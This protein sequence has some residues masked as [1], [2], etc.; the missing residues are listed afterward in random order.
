MRLRHWRRCKTKSGQMRPAGCSR[1][2]LCQQTPCR[3]YA[4]VKPRVVSRRQMRI[5]TI[6]VPAV[7]LFRSILILVDTQTQATT[8]TATT[9][10]YNGLTD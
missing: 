8:T 6:I 9:T 7:A 5:S 3:T 1:V 10:P 2:V 4:E